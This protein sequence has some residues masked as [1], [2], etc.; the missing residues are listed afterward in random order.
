MLLSVMVQGI[1]DAFLQDAD[2]GHRA[3]VQGLVC[4]GF[5]TFPL[6]PWPLPPLGLPGQQHPSILQELS[7]T[8]EWDL[9]HFM[10]Q[11]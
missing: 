8:A 3:K 9:C 7:L 10:G 5:L 1:G 6:H 2:L 4:A 11:D